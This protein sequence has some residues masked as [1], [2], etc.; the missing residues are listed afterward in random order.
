M[1]HFVPHPI[2]PQA[3]A[4]EGLRL[5]RISS[6]HIPALNPSAQGCSRCCTS[7]CHRM[8]PPCSPPKA[9]A[10]SPPCCTLTL[11]KVCCSC[12]CS[13]PCFTTTSSIL[14]PRASV[15][16]APLSPSVPSA[17]SALTPRDV[18]SGAAASSPCSTSCLR[19]DSRKGSRVHSC[20]QGPEQLL[21]WE[22]GPAEMGGLL[23]LGGSTWPICSVMLLLF[24]HG[25]ALQGPLVH[26]VGWK[27][28]WVGGGC[29][30]VC[31]IAAHSACGKCSPACINSTAS[32]STSREQSP[33]G[34]QEEQHA[35]NASLAACKA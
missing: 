12:R 2:P 25:S 34:M 7:H 4:A 22:W 24:L 14:Q 20:M 35:E 17:P 27:W 18:W 29:G 3:S 21:G 31:G 9:L 15:C 26:G 13:T 10:G 19:A 23:G 5:H 1:H 33:P 16:T 11:P 6:C 32:V 8:Q 28:V 30:R